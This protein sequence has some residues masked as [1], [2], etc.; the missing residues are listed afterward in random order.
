[1]NTIHISK[2]DRFELP[3]RVVYSMVGFNGIKSNRMSF[4]VAELPP[5][6][7]M[8]PHK[9]VIEEEIIYIIEG[10]GKLYVGKDV[11]EKI[12]P[13]T[14]IVAPKNIKHTIENE[15]SNIMRWCWVFNPPVKIGSHATS[16]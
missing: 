8:E 4:G 10:F 2:A 13:G 1:M 3:G 9:H 7:K 14:V 16:E 5:K 11:I 12:E 6:S 15:S